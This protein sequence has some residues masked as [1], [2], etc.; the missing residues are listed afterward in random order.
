MSVWCADDPKAMQLQPPEHQLHWMNSGSSA[1]CSFSLPTQSACTS[2]NDDR[3]AASST[4]AVPPAPTMS[5][6]ASFAMDVSLP[7]ISLSLISRNCPHKR[8][9]RACQDHLDASS[10]WNPQHGMPGFSLQVQDAAVRL[11]S[12]T[13]CQGS[14]FSMT[15]ISTDCAL[16]DITGYTAS[17]SLKKG[18]VAPFE[19]Q[20]MQGSVVL[21]T[22][23]TAASQRLY[24]LR[25]VQH[26]QHALMARMFATWVQVCRA[27]CC[28]TSWPCLRQHQLNLGG[29]ITACGCLLCLLCSS[30][31]TIVKAS[32]P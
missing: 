9:A 20:G 30:A 17:G 28:L 14:K 13:S 3:A 26:N 10:T 27:R 12:S 29:Y 2:T 22:L 6:T 18:S 4:C 32:L 23:G 25:R 7:H 8:A 31:E 1:R 19:A 5:S 16:R 11:A 24:C 15:C 21:H